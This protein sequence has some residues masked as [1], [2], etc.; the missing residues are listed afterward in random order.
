IT[1]LGMMG[2]EPFLVSSALLMVLAQR[3]VRGICPQCK[4]PYE[5]ELDWLIKLGVPP[6]Q[7]QA[8]GGKVTLHKGKG[9]DNCAGTGYRGRQGLY[10]ILEVTDIVRQLILD[11]AST[12]AIKD[13]GIKQGM[14][15]LRTC[16]VRKLLAGVTT[17]EEMIRVT[18]SDI[19]G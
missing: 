4:E 8:R 10:E 12:H 1:R 3:L 17:V 6:T 18:A 5:V 14:L 16:A 15:T 19:E 11:K 7:L 9:C 2:V 13:A